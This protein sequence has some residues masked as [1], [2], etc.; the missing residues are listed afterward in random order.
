MHNIRETPF[1]VGVTSFGLPC[2]PESP[3]V[4]TRVAPYLDWIVEAMIERGASVDQQ[5]FNT[6]ACAHRYVKLRDYYDAIVTKRNGS[7]S[8]I[9]AFSQHL[10]T[11]PG[12]PPF[13]A[14]LGWGNGGGTN[15]NCYGVIVDE[16]TVLTVADCTEFKG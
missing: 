6:T 8:E 4:Y 7:R 11:R 12:L 3:G 9:D 14:K 16:D 1:I 5:T 13:V 10:I 15:D 2:S